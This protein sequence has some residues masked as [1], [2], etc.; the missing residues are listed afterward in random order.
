MSIKRNAKTK[1]FGVEEGLAT[2]RLRQARYYDLGLDCSRWA[3]EHSVTT[4]RKCDLLDIGTYDGVTRRY[5][6]LHPGEE[7]DQGVYLDCQRREDAEEDE[8]SHEARP[9]LGQ[10]ALGGGGERV[11]G[12][13]PGRIVDVELHA[14]S[15]WSLAGWHGPRRR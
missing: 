12:R 6:E 9:A 8:R 5:C 15:L 10:G 3:E 4:G 11:R 2:Y 14:P 13:A 1:A 7:H